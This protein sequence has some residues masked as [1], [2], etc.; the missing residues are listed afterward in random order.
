MSARY[1]IVQLDGLE[2]YRIER[3]TKRWFRDEFY[4]KVVKFS[5]SCFGVTCYTEFDD[6]MSAVKKLEQIKLAERTDKERHRGN[7]H[8]IRTV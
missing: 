5:D 2:V 4:W 3:L 6:A 8:P 7:W 1:R